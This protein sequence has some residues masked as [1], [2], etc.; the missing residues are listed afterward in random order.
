MS[1]WGRREIL[2]RRGRR[3][4]GETQEERKRERG[5]K[6]LASP[7]VLDREDLELRRDFKIMLKQIYPDREFQGKKE[8][9]YVK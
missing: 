1:L 3:E 6:Q 7:S 8:S 5:G 4:E 2:K 9:G